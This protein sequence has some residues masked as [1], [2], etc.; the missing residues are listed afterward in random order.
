[1]KCLRQTRDRCY[2]DYTA[3]GFSVTALVRK[4]G[5]TIRLNRDRQRTQYSYQENVKTRSRRYRTG[6]QHWVTPCMA[7]MHGSFFLSIA[8]VLRAGHKDKAP[9]KIRYISSQLEGQPT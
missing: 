9:P 7:S 5:A 2:D 4:K 6:P 3:T 1:M 8:L